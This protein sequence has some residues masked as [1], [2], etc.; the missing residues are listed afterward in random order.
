MDTDQ[1]VSL[2]EDGDKFER[3]WW[4]RLK[5]YLLNYDVVWRMHVVPL[6]SPGSILLRAGID[7]DLEPPA[8]MST[9]CQR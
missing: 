8:T 3:E 6:R 4:A 9:L 5:P 2:L 1:G 7:E